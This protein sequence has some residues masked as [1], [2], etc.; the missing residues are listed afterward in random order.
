MRM[1]ICFFRRAL[2]RQWLNAVKIGSRGKYIEW[3]RLD[4]H[5][6]LIRLVV[7]SIEPGTIQCIRVRKTAYPCQQA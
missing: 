4:R 5:R 2:T 3:D 7:Y 6:Q 1:F